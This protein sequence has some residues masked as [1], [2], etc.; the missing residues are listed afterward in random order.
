M[1]SISSGEKLILNGSSI[2][3]RLVPGHTQGS[4]VYYFEEIHSAFVG[5]VI[6]Y[7]SIGRTDLGDG[8]QEQLLESIR[9]QVMTLPGETILY[10]GHGQPTTVA[11][12]ARNN[13]FLN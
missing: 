4:V 6:F 10:P 3:V 12:E 8:T 7:H 5:D 11:E 9:S 13:P 2:E 1:Q